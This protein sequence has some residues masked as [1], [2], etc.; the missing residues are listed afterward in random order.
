MLYQE[1]SPARKKR[2]YLAVE[3]SNLIKGKT[4]QKFSAKKN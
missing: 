2:I 3:L 1:K 4:L